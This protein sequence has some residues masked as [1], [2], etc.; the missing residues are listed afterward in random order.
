M[1]TWLALLGLAMGAAGVVAMLVLE[2]RW[3][4][5]GRARAAEALW[6]EPGGGW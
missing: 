4:E 5:Q 6:D 2:E 1:R 3:E